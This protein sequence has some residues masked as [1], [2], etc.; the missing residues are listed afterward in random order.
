MCIVHRERSTEPSRA[1]DAQ[2]RCEG[3]T[4][5]DE[6]FRTICNGRAA[7][8]L[9]TA[10]IAARDVDGPSLLLRADAEPSTDV[11]RRVVILPRELRV[12]VSGSGGA[13]SHALRRLTCEWVDGQRGR[14][15]SVCTDKTDRAQS[16]RTHLVASCESARR[17]S[18]V[19]MLRPNGVRWCTEYVRTSSVDTSRWL[20]TSLVCPAARQQAVCTR[21][22]IPTAVLAEQDVEGPAGHRLTSAGGRCRARRL[23]RTPGASRQGEVV[24]GMQPEGVSESERGLTH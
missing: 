10:S 14:L 23:L 19:R 16:T 3:M 22:P 13:G 15:G 4:A 18:T 5:P 7:L 21:E 11:R 2:V 9:L 24:R 12:R 17:E 8:E 20:R 1:A 6:Q